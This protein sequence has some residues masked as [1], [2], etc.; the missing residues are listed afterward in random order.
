MPA[1]CRVSIRRSPSSAGHPPLATR[2]AGGAAMTACSDR[3]RRRHRAGTQLMMEWQSGRDHVGPSK[4]FE[5][6]VAMLVAGHTHHGAL[7]PQHPAVLPCREIDVLAVGHGRSNAASAVRLHALLEHAR[8][9]HPCR[10]SNR[11]P[12]RRERSA[13]AGG[14][15]TA[16]GAVPDRIGQPGD[17]ARVPASVV[18]VLRRTDGRIV[19]T[20]SQR[21]RCPHE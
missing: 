10:A 17:L 4:T 15:G 6:S 3:Q 9:D 8:P 2:R 1:V 19:L 18:R 21:D 5:Q 12:G 7:R 16:A 11:P 20:P 14:R 13:R